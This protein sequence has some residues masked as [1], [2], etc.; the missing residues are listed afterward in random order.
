MQ[1]D[2]WAAR[3]VP[4]AQRLAAA[5]VPDAGREARLIARWAAGL[6]GA[7]FTAQI[8]DRPSTAQATQFDRAI[9]ERSER[10]PL[11]HITG[12]R[13]FAGRHFRVTADV[14]DPRPETE[15]LVAAALEQPFDT[16]LD[17]GTGSGCILLSLL[18]ERPHAR[19]LGTDASAAALEVAKENAA[20]LALQE[21]AAFLRTDWAAGAGGPF[22]LV[23]SNPP[24]LAAPEIADLAPE[25]R[26][27]EPRAALTSGPDGLEAYR[28]IAA[29]LTSLL[30]PGGRTLF[31]IGPG[32]AQAV[33]H[34]LQATG[35]TVI[36][37]RQDFDGRNRV[38]EAFAPQF[39]TKPPIRS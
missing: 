3:L 4:A 8:R 28:A 34:I 17:I 22:D 29:D 19:G 27:H 16:V 6:D 10:R 31:E 13:L 12:Q 26:L 15:G 18:V 39:L 38:I 11:S 21:R 37:P 7:A 32:Q 20:R 36:P 14:L 1:S 23:V 5:G 35:L 9:A 25:V 24:Y 30:A 33:T 2:S